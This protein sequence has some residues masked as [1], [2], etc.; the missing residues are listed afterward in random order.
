MIKLKNMSCSSCEKPQKKQTHITNKE[1]PYRM[2]DGR[3]FTDY[4]TRCTIDYQKKTNN[5]FKS[6]FD[7]RQFLIHN[8]SRLMKEHENS[9]KGHNMNHC[10]F[11]VFNWT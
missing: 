1:C 9:A 8:A 3:N 2:A 7:E 5:L 6:N 4:R 10:C 11:C